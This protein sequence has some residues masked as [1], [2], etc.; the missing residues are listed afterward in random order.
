MTVKK[1]TEQEVSAFVQG[2]AT[3]T[4]DKEALIDFLDK[5]PASVDAKNLGWTA[6]HMAASWDNEEVTKLLLERGAS[7]DEKNSQ[8]RTAFDIASDFKYE[9]VLRELDHAAKQRAAEA[10]A[11]AAAIREIEEER[12]RLVSDPRLRRDL[13]VRG[14]P[15]KFPSKKPRL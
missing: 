3:F 7:L 10:E 12:I 5:Y 15:L 6:L 9:S 8:G 2:L 11:T 13:P 1:P 4:V 14:Q